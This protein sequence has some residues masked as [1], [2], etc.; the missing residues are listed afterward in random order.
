M[1]NDGRAGAA[2]VRVMMSPTHEAGTF[3]RR[4]ELARNSAARMAG[5]PFVTGMRLCCVKQAPPHGSHL[6]ALEHQNENLS[7]GQHDD[8]YYL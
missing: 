1:A 8:I 4:S 2:N 5:P 6:A 7:N 3:V